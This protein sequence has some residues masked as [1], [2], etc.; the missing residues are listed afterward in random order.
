MRYN[1]RQNRSPKYFPTLLPDATAVMW[2]QRRPMDKTEN[3]LK[4]PNPTEVHPNG[5][6]KK[7]TYKYDNQLRLNAQIT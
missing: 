3:N 2:L 1:W 7:M 5:V 6:E 4:S